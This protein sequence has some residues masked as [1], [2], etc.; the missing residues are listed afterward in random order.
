MKYIFILLL[1]C[2]CSSKAYIM[3]N[4][5]Q[6]EVKFKKA[7]SPSERKWATIYAFVIVSILIPK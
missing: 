6:Q 4:G 2:S 7:V 5:V 3:K 1:L